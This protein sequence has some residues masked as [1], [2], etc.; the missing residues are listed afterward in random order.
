MTREIGE[1]LEE[2]TE[3]PETVDQSTENSKEY[4][5]A[6][7]LGK[8][9]AENGCD[10]LTLSELLEETECFGNGYRKGYVEN[11]GGDAH[12]QHC[13]DSGEGMYDGSSCPFC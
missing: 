10:S 5:E 9:D 7:K 12:C 4:Q 6:Y 3:Q 1:I 8:Q 2:V 11:Y 13:N